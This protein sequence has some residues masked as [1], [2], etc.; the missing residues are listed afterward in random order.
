MRSGS[1]RAPWNG[2]DWLV[3]YREFED[4][5][6]TDARRY[7]YVSAGGG[8]RR[9]K[10]LCKLTPGA[11]VFCHVPREGY[12]GVGEVTSDE[13]VP[14]QQF[15]VLVND[16]ETPILEAP[17]ETPNIQ[18]FLGEPD[19]EEH[20]VRIRWLE[21]VPLD[22]AIWEPGLSANQNIVTRLCDART[23]R[24]VLERLGIE[25]R[26]PESEE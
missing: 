18:N 8:A 24:V 14:L 25:G 12:V 19:K 21:T 2:T 11:R 4:R 17:L 20:F 7:G 26:S 5:R 9:I 22:Q 15:T 13:P 10:Q 3:T 23:R 16:V 6:W 1:E